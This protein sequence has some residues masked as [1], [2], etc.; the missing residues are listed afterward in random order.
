MS[1]VRWDFEATRRMPG[2]PLSGRRCAAAARCRRAAASS[3]APGADDAGVDLAGGGHGQHAHLRAPVDAQAD[4]HREAGVAGDEVARA[5]DGI[6]HPDPAVAAGATPSS[7]ISSDRMASSGKACAQ[8]RHDAGRWPAW[9]ATVTGSSPVFVSTV[10]SVPQKPRTRSAGLAGRAACATSSSR[11]RVHRRHAGGPSG[12]A[13]GCAAPAAAPARHGTSSS[14]V[15]ST[16]TR[17]PTRSAATPIRAGEGQ[18]PNRWM[19]T[20]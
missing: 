10:R 20:V 7:G 13:P 5:V 11:S 14:P 6:D 12:R 15:T 3:P 18:S 17:R 9:S 1:R 8:A 16:G 2:G 4:H 19:A